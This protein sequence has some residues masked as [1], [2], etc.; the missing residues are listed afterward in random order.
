MRIFVAVSIILALSL[1]ALGAT[2]YRAPHQAVVHQ[3]GKATPPKGS[4]TPV[5]VELFTS[6]G[7]SSCP[8]AD[9]LLAQLDAQQPVA[10]AEVIALEQHVDYWNQLGWV[11]P[12]SSPERTR[13]QQEYAETFGNDSVDTPQMV[14]DGAVEFVGSREGQA[15][16]VIAE[17]AS[18]GKTPVQLT[19]GQNG[20]G[21]GKLLLTAHVPKLANAPSNDSVEVFLAITESRLHSDVTRGEN[22]GKALDHAGVVRELKRIGVAG[23]KTDPAFS[24][25]ETITLVSGWKRENLRAVLFLQ[26]KRSRRVIGAASIPLI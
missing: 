21:P 18:R 5:V 1:L 25:T 3:D 13:R 6:E 7:C 24:G 17:A 2:L 4:R 14:V 12:F 15:R 10:A 8:P 19:A 16:Q 26:E 9:A 11:D 23:A 22:A 20:A